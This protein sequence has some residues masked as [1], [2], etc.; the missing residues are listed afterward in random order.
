M[1]KN[2]II[3]VV[4]ELMKEYFQSEEGNNLTLYHQEFVKEGPDKVLRV[5][6]DKTDDYVSTDDCERVSRFLS[7]KLDEMDLIEN[8]YYLEVSS[9]GMDR[10]LV[11]EEHFNRYL[12]ELVDV[13]L[14]REI[15]GSKKLQGTLAKYN[16]G[17][18]L[19]Q[20][21]E[22]TGSHRE[23]ELKG[24]DIAKVNLAVVI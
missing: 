21:E 15:E 1:A 5:F 16:D 19:L 14:Y 10:V 9:P 23:I 20:I 22:E 6:I 12:G 3:D 2:K 8:N 18:I 24:K 17:D 13:S 4:E 7:D 11:T